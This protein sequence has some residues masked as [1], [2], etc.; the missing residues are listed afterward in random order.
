MKLLLKILAALLAVFVAIIAVSPLIIKIYFPPEKI[1]ALLVSNAEQSLNRKLRLGDV[2]FNLLKGLTLKGLA[3]SEAP[4]FSAGTFG[5]ADSFGLRIQWLPLLHKKIVIDK[6]SIEGLKLNIAK[7]PDGLY[8]FSTL[9]ASTGTAPT[10]ASTD[11]AAP[12]ELSISR[13]AISDGSVVYK[14]RAAGREWKLSKINLKARHFQLDG[15]FDLELSLEAEGRAAD[16]PL[17]ARMLFAGKLD[18]A[19]QNPEKMWVNFRNLSIAELRSIR[20]GADTNL[21]ATVSGTVK[22]IAASEVNLK[23]AVAAGKTKILG[24]DFSGKV[25]L[26]GPKA[27]LAA[28]GDFKLRMPGFD[29][30]S[31]L[32]SYR[33]PTFPRI[34]VPPLTTSGR[35]NWQG[36][37]VSIASW[38]LESAFGALDVSGSLRGLGQASSLKSAEPTIKLLIKCR[39]FVLQELA[40]ISPA[41]RDMNLRG[42]GSFNLTATGRVHNPALTGKIQFSDGG[43]VVAGLKVSDMSGSAN[44]DERNMLLPELKARIA[45]G[46]LTMNLAVKNYTKA[47]E[48]DVEANLTRLDLG[49]FLAAKTALAPASA[50]PTASRGKI[51]KPSAGPPASAKGKFTIGQLVH[52]NAEAKDLQLNWDLSGITPDFRRLGGWAK[53]RANG[54]KFSSLG[55]MAAQSKWV[56]VL[57][58]PLMVFQKIGDIGG[59]KLFPDFNNM[60]FSELAGDYVFKEGVMVLKDSHISSEAAAVSAQGS[61]DIPAEKLN[62]VVSAQ[63][64]RIAPLEIEVRGSFENPSIKPRIAKF[65][66]QPAKRILENPAKQILGEPAKQLLDSIFKGN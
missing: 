49:K 47:P 1:R 54:G 16:Q 9:A 22:G 63:V 17:A 55:D 37:N 12:L 11:T 4:D 65:L 13:A 15:P 5:A 10:T 19:N 21:E 20:R 42:R 59:I 41:T 28:G 14:D 3:I 46:A 56:K 40:R 50:A 34:V 48:I 8:N 18:L 33:L 58:M 38:H 57:I 64:G 6:I 27:G 36:D 60:Q 2:S 30:S 62:L 52:P 23:A 61:I 31:G 35:V 53:L 66:I 24:V 32:L 7:G 26:P 29:N 51:E 39:L 44:F 45:D 43:A 25:V